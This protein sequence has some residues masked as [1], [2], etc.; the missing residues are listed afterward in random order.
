MRPVHVLSVDHLRRVHLL[1]LQPLDEIVVEDMA[2]WSVS[3][4]MAQTCNRNISHLFVCD[5]QVIL[6][7]L[8]DA[9]LFPGQVTG[10]D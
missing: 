8:Q 7:F 1:L 4:I 9:H 5:M 6:L 3:E 2:E 10:A